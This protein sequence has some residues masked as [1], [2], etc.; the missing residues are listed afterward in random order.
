MTD[1]SSFGAVGQEPAMG[2]GRAAV[3]GGSADSTIGAETSALGQSRD[4]GETTEM[5]VEPYY[6]IQAWRDGKIADWWAG[7][8][9]VL[10]QD[11]A[12]ELLARGYDV[13]VFKDGRFLGW[14]ERADGTLPKP[15]EERCEN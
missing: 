14:V 3:L 8:D 11:A 15:K 2:T 6:A 12:R 9:E 5:R 10:A 1:N 13:E 4:S 7:H